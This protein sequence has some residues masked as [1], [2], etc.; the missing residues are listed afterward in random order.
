MDSPMTDTCS[1]L[2][3]A[4][5]SLTD[6]RDRR[7]V[8]HP[9]SGLLALTFLGLLCRQCDFASIARWAK[10]HYKQLKE[11][12]GFEKPYP[13]HATTISRACQKFSPDEFN[14]ALALFLTSLPGVGPAC[15]IDGKTDKQAEGQDGDPI[16]VLNVFAHDLK[17]ALACWPVGGGKGTEAE[18]LKS[19]LKEL[20]GAYP[21]LKVLTMD[22]G[23]TQRNLAELI[24]E[25][26]RDYVM[27][28]KDNQPNLHETAKAAFADVD[29]DKPD[30]ET[31]GKVKGG[32]RPGGSGS[33]P[34]RRSTPGRLGASRG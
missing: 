10:Q 7:G 33:I 34:G 5:D 19:R 14:S 2:A 1:T 11:P 22:A 3:L 23:F 13:P 8:R 32:W 15:A 17:V 12:L 28:I 21:S 29:L 24:V 25:N 30:A 31:I 26:G 9:F 16:H 6:P 27:A 20:L 18:V 4:F